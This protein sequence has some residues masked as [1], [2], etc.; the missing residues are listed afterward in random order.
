MVSMILVWVVVS[1]I[2]HCIAIGALP[3]SSVMGANEKHFSVK[4]PQVQSGLSTLHVSTKAFPE[5]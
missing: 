1:L 4:L 2:P 5:Y 3:T